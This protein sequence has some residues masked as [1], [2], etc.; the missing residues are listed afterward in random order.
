MCKYYEFHLK[1]FNNKILK[2]GIVI[3]IID[4]KSV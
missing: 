3:K 2:N 1:F 4:V